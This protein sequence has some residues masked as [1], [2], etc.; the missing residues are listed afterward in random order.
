MNR[1][2]IITLE[3]TIAA[4]AIVVLIGTYLASGF[5]YDA[6]IWILLIA[7]GIGAM[8]LLKKHNSPEV[9]R[10]IAIMGVLCIGI[11]FAGFLT[12]TPLL[13]ATPTMGMVFGMVLLLLHWRMKRQDG[14]LGLQDERSLR[15]GTYGIACSWYLTY[16]VVI[17]L[18]TAIS[19]GG[20]Q[21]PAESVILIL[22]ILMPISTILFQ[23]YYNHKGDV[24]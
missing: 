4:L 6:L 2:A 7:L 17:L 14:D 16:I 15:I 20:M 13:P 18:A 19:L 3:I 5:T 24:Y 10:I 9:R 12:P 11:S 22:I 21:V 8:Y 1:T 23:T